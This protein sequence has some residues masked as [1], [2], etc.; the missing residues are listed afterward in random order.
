MGTWIDICQRTDI[1]P[2]TG[3]CALL[4]EAQVAV[5]RCRQTDALYA[6]D[7][8]DPIGRAQVLSRG[9]IGCVAGEPVVAS[10][11]YKQ[12]FNLSTGVCLQ[13]PKVQLK[14]YDVRYLDDRVQL[15]SMP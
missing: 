1:V 8:Y 3:V 15:S 6:I 4:G 13:S 5:F 2:G 7:N 11:L 14:T 9:I 10:P 12:H